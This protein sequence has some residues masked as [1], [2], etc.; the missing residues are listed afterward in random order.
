MLMN[1]P[2]NN[3]AELLLDQGTKLDIAF[4]PDDYSQEWAFLVKDSDEQ[5]SFFDVLLHYDLVREWYLA[6][7]S[8]LAVRTDHMEI[9]DEESQATAE[10]AEAESPE[11]ASSTESSEDSNSNEEE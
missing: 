11:E 5:I 3:G 4:D 1:L 9:V 2:R 7:R 10:M 6:N 8:A